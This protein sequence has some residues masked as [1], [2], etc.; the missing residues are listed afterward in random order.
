VTLTGNKREY[1][2]DDKYTENEMLHD[3]KVNTASDRESKTSL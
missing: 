3:R 1:T 2:G